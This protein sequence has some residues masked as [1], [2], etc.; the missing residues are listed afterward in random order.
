MNRSVS[1]DTFVP[2]KPLLMYFQ[3]KTELNL[4]NSV[5]IGIQNKLYQIQ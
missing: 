5:L 1:F 2:L 4:I 3:I